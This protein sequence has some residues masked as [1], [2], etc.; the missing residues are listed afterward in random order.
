M[1]RPPVNQGFSEGEEICWKILE[2]EGKKDE[3]RKKKKRK[4]VMANMGIVVQAC[5]LVC[6]F[7]TFYQ[8]VTNRVMKT[9]VGN[10]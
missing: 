1:Q 3:K 6:H 5:C 9:C 8:R 4:K 2:A 10:I 7:A